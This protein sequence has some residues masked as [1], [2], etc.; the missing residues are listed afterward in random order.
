MCLTGW[1]LLDWASGFALMILVQC[2]CLS[3]FNKTQLNKSDF[4][5]SSCNKYSLVKRQGPA[6][7]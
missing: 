5:Q 4:K 6:T 3:H 1:L 2:F 7:G